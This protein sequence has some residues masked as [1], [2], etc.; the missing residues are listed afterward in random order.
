M[1]FALI[2]ILLPQ[3]LF[4]SWEVLQ[5]INWSGSKTY[6]DQLVG[7]LS[8]VICEEGF[9]KIKAVTD[10]RKVTATFEIQGEIKNKKL[11]LE[12]VGMTKLQDLDLKDRKLIDA[13]GMFKFPWGSYL[14]SSESD[15]SQKPR[16]PV[17]LV[18]FKS[19]GT[20]VRN[21][22]VP[23]VFLPEP[24]GLQTQGVQNNLGFE[25]LSISPDK[26]QFMAAT[27]ASLIQEIQT[28][29]SR[30]Q[31][32]SLAEAWKATPTKQLA[33]LREPSIANPLKFQGGVSEILWWNE[34][35]VLVVERYLDS[36]L[37]MQIKV[38]LFDI[39]Q[40]H[41]IEGIDKLSAEISNWGSKIEKINLTQELSKQA[42]LAQNVEAVCEGPNLEGKRTL[43]FLSD[44]NFLKLAPSQWIWVKTDEVVK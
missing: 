22:E 9:K 39:S 2:L 12:I 15:Y 16:R 37:R 43:L 13:E 6:K 25:G 30:F 40:S 5:T 1:K 26:T 19:D 41:S 27:E 23:K 24:S 4:A 20:F 18:E 14:F 44:N 29:W 28:R 17:E 10:D 42:E 33:Y 38:F 35:Q 31:V 11:S 3:M 36:Q 8:A 32:Y 7:G 34:N 21:Y